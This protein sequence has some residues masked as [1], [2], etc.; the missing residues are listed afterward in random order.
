MDTKLIRVVESQADASIGKSAQFY[1]ERTDRELL[2]RLVARYLAAVMF[3]AVKSHTDAS[4]GKS[5]Q[6]HAER[7]DRELLGCPVARYSAVVVVYVVKSHAR[8]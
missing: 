7:T 2:G 5:A 1:A 8:R 4:I 6:F 3:Y